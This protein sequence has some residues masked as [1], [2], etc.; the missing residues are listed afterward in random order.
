MYTPIHQL[1]MGVMDAIRR[2]I[3][4]TGNHVWVNITYN[5]LFYK[6]SFTTTH[7]KFIILIHRKSVTLLTADCY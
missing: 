3:Y 7:Y 5:C 6:V 1:A 4:V 2:L